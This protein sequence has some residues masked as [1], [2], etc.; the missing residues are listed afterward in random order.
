MKG[1]PKSVITKLALIACLTLLFVTVPVFAGAMQTGGERWI[2]EWEVKWADSPDLAAVPGS[3]TASE[4]WSPNQSGM[5]LPKRPGTSSTLW[6][7][8]KLPAL[9]WDIP[10]MLIPKIYGQN[11][12][13][14]VLTP[15]QRND[16]DK[17]LYIGVQSAKD[18][19]G[20]RH[21]IELGNYPELLDN[22]VKRDLIDIIL[23]CAF[24][25]IA[26]VMLIC[27]VFL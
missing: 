18:R 10:S 1:F 16:S 13:N 4:G 3:V 8:T 27:S 7:R 14:K 24:V 15:L 6:I 20:L 22:Y 17:I 5:A 9:N 2:T 11:I 25:F 21:G 26:L 23:G 12:D 19:I